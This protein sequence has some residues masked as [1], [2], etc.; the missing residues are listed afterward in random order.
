MYNSSSLY[1]NYRTRTFAEIFNEYD[2]EYFGGSDEYFDS[3][4]QKSKFV[5][6]LIKEGNAIPVY[7]DGKGVFWLLYARYGN[8]HIASSD[9]N[10]FLA[11]LHSIMYEYGPTWERKRKLQQELL[12]LSLQNAREGNRLI[13]N[14]AEN[15][16]SQP[17]TVDTD[18]LNFV[19]SQNVNKNMRSPLEAATLLS[20]VLDDS[21]T[22]EFVDK[23]KPLFLTIVE[24]EVP[25]WYET[26]PEEE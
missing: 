8:S 9:E 11:Q 17:S 4:W 24:P 1:G 25:L 18:E 2:K 6:I 19:N 5:T 7:P 22:K 26:Y 23:F 13:S 16:S 14:R 21:I 12:R 20:A 10:R 15:P 3:L